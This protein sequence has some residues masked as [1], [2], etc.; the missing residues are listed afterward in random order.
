MRRWIP[1]DCFGRILANRS[2]SHLGGHCGLPL[3]SVKLW[4]MCLCCHVCC[5]LHRAESRKGLWCASSSCLLGLTVCCY[6]S[7]R[8]CSCAIHDIYNGLAL[9][10]DAA[11]ARHQAGLNLDSCQRISFCSNGFA[12]SPSS[13][14]IYAGTFLSIR[15]YAQCQ[16]QRHST[17]YNPTF[18]I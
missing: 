7:W 11:P 14:K 1:G 8:C 10:F 18:V 5:A 9:H 13:I 2:V 4:G 15:V 3:T 17:T 12:P 6:H 16:T